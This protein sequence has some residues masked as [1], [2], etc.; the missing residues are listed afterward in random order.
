MKGE[1]GRG[2]VWTVNLCLRRP[3]CG[4]ILSREE[5]AHAE[6]VQ[7]SS[8]IGPGDQAASLPLLL[9]LCRPWQSVCAP[10]L[11]QR[12]V[13]CRRQEATPHKDLPPLCWAEISSERT[14]INSSGCSDKMSSDPRAKVNTSWAPEGPGGGLSRLHS[15]SAPR[16]TV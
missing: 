5:W 7:G 4:T 15:S 11:C 3:E 8:R 16:L 13:K 14:D 9:C 2:R 10:E 12:S 6:R 1:Q